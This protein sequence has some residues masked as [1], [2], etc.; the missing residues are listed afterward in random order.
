[1][2]IGSPAA[3]ETLR[4]ALDQTQGLPKMGVM[5]SLGQLRDR[6]SELPLAKLLQDSDEQIAQ[7]AASALGELG[8]ATSAEILRKAPADTIGGEVIGQALVVCAD[9]LL[10]DNDVTGAQRVY[11]SLYQP[12]AASSLRLAALRGLARCG[13]RDAIGLAIG[14]EDRHVQQLGMQLLRESLGAE[15]TDEKMTAWFDETISKTADAS[16]RRA[17]VS[18]LAA[19]SGTAALQLA[20]EVMRR[21]EAVREAAAD[22]AARLGRDLASSER[23]LVKLAMQQVIALSHNAETVKLA[24]VALRDAARSVN[25]ALNATVSSPDNLEPDGGSG[26]DAAAV[27]GNRATYWDETDNQPLYRFQVRFAKPTRFNT[28]VVVGHAYQSHSPKNFEV[29]CDGELVTSVTDAPYD[30]KTNETHVNFPRCECTSL[31][32]KITGYYGGSPGIRELEVYDVDTGL[33]SASYVPLPAGPRQLSWQNEAG[34][35]ALLNYSRVVWALHYGPEVAK[36]YFDPLGLLDGVSLVWNSPPDHPWHHGLWFAWKGINGVNYWEED[37]T[38]HRSEG[39][40]EVVSSKVTAGEDFSA[41]IEL[42]MAYH[43]PGEPVVLRETRVI[44]VSVPDDQGSYAVDWRST[45]RGW[46]ARPGAAGWH[47]RWRIRGDV[48][49]HR[50]RHAR[51]A[52]HRW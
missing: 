28:V 35:L 7:A 47:G 41:R 11:Q 12:S 9:R 22:A 49:S 19:V 25:L 45:F 48:R 3:I 51:L 14:D 20:V 2:Q 10:A 42:N 32:L 23:E 31:E 46:G 26:P 36:P 6:P 24:D 33:A 37:G 27:D 29:L 18:Q 43:K 30:E 38:T 52:A 1:M 17:I 44:R 40:T 16:R 8:T 4:S 34:R 50:Q 39:L 21:D 15:Q 13:S 5:Y